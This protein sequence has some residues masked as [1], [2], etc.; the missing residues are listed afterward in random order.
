MKSNNITSKKNDNFLE[1]GD[2]FPFIK[3]GARDI[4]N[5][6]NDKYTLIINTKK[7]VNITQNLRNKYNILVRRKNENIFN[8][9]PDMK[10]NIY[11]L[12]LSP[13]RRIKDIFD[14]TDITYLENLDLS[15]YKEN[16]NFPYLIIENALDKELLNEIIDFYK[17]KKEK[18]Q[19]ISHQHS[20]KDRLHV[21]PDLELTKKIDSKLSRSVLPE[22]RKIFYFDVKHREDYKICSYDSE[23]SGRF[24]S[25]RDTPSPFQHRKYAM[26]LLLNDDYEGGELYLSEYG[27]KIKP[28]A[29]TA[30]I[31]PGLS[32]HQVL[33]VTKGS[34]M[35]MITF[36][37]SGLKKRY[38]M[39]SHFFKDKNVEFSK[40]YPL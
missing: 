25:H 19:T 4:H 17:K 7:N 37:T 15:Q 20:T 6:V 14:D 23:T 5:L 35:A 9:I 34:R 8:I 21:H 30:F 26:S 13:N 38:E 10:E 29:N 16:Y 33:E 32:S 1:K 39:K 12:L 18:G 28:K 36:F 40:I 11:V 27:M 24:H 31:F 22:L 2:F 3:I